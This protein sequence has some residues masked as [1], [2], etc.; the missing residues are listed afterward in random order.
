MYFCTIYISLGHLMSEFRYRASLNNIFCTKVT[1]AGDYN[2]DRAA[3][4][5]NYS[6]NRSSG[7]GNSMG[8]F[9]SGGNSGGGGENHNGSRGGGSLKSKVILARS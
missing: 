2:S 6:R 1:N 3:S 8:G 7:G 5:D 9:G 4:G